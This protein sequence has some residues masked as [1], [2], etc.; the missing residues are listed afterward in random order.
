[1]YI[2]SAQGVTGKFTV[3]IVRTTGNILCAYISVILVYRVNKHSSVQQPWMSTDV[4]PI[5]SIQMWVQKAP[6]EV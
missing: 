1:M 6:V 4:F 5:I 2:C 3:I